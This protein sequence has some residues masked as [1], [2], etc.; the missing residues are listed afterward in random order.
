MEIIELI[1]LKRSIKK[2]QNK[3]VEHPLIEQIVEA[4]LY[5]PS[6]RN[7][8]NVKMLVVENKEL[9]QQIAKIN[10]SI[11]GIDTD[12]FYG[13]PVV[14]VV[15]ANRNCSTYMEDGSLV[16]ANLMLGAHF[17]GVDSCWIHRARETFETPEGRKL[18]KEWGIPDEYIGIG[19][20]ILGYHAGAYPNPSPRKSDRVYYIK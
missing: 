16:M 20:C 1:K 3:P 17:L 6:G 8:Q 18:A 10:A 12:P 14:I 7:G 4:G 19:N 11:L 9:V 5:A 2:Y 15:F 13:A